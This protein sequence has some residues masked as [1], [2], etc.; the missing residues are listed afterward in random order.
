MIKIRISFAK[1]TDESKNNSTKTFATAFNHHF[2][3]NTFSF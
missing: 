1:E 2:E 3:Y